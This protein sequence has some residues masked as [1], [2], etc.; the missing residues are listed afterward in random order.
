[1]PAEQ[2][3]QFAE[4]YEEILNQNIRLTGEDS[5]YFAAYKARHLARWMGTN[6]RGRILDYGCGVG[7][8][9]RFL[10]R[11][12]RQATVDGCDVSRASLA[13]LDAE[14]RAQGLFTSDM[15]ELP[16]FYDL[17][18]LSNVL[19]HVALEQR[20][21]T[22]LSLR[23]RLAPGGRI[24]I[25]EHNPLNPLTRRAVAHCAFDEDAILLPRREAVRYLRRAGLRIAERDYIVFFPRRLAALRGLEPWL[26]WCPLGAQY[27]LLAGTESTATARNTAGGVR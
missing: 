23:N 4:N 6:F 2:F 10:K 5:E 19:H 18:V 1:V 25:V 11:E 17:I 26:N 24:A 14:L 16:H 22:I 20:Q 8:L 27:A 21:E 3:D 12:L 13:R 7:A 15:R 9:A